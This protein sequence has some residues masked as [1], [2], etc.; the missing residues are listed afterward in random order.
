MPIHLL[1]SGVTV[2]V[3]GLVSTGEEVA[4]VCRGHSDRLELRHKGRVLGLLWM[5]TSVVVFDHVPS[6]YVLQT[7]TAATEL[8]SD[9]VLDRTGIGYASLERQVLSADSSDEARR[10]FGD[11]V[12]LKEGEALFSVKPGA[13]QVVDRREG[14]REFSGDLELPA[15]T[16][17]GEYEL[18]AFAFRDGQPRLV[19]EDTV[20]LRLSG[21]SALAEQTA[22]QHGLLY[23]VLA[24]LIAIAAGMV[25]GVVF[26]LGSRRGH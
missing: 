24:V 2:K 9:G 4:V 20:T 22:H 6:V 13:L 17:P 14:V 15:R 1:F 25:S 10:L 5:N 19:G 26:G 11:L 18:R 16:P 12:R 21:F 23:G 7:S 8:A 3:H